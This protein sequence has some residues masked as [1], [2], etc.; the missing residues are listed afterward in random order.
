MK[1]KYFIKERKD[2]AKVNALG[3]PL[4]Y[5]ITYVICRTFVWRWLAE[6]IPSWFI[7][8]LWVANVKEAKARLRDYGSIE[9]DWV[10]WMPGERF[11]YK[12]HAEDFLRRMKSTPDK[13]YIN[14]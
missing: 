9:V 14:I 13:F 8:Y 12:H 6:L 7:W 3:E 10:H 2:L 11:R 4:E 1:Y 5:D